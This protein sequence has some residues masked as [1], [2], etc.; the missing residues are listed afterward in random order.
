MNI[1]P[2][3]YVAYDKPMID[4]AIMSVF[5]TLTIPRMCCRPST[6]FEI[7][8]SNSIVYLLNLT[9]HDWSSL[10]HGG[11]SGHATIISSLFVNDE[12]S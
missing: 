1:A 8:R 7:F 3:T 9:S 10:Y 5:I 4:A 12:I 6:L 2:L 11:L